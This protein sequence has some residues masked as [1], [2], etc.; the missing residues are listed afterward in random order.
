MIKEYKSLKEASKYAEEIYA[1]V[2]FS[3]LDKI[4]L[5]P[6]TEDEKNEVENRE[7]VNLAT[8]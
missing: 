4:Y 6:E 3:S 8:G 2:F 5:V 1:V 7:A